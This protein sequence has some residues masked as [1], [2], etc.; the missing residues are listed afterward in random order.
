MTTFAMTGA[1]GK[2][3]QY[4]LKEGVVD[5]GCDI[6]K[7]TTV[8]GAFNRVR[9]DVVVHLASISD[10]NIC[11]DPANIE[12]VVN[13]NIRG[14]YN[15]L[16][17][18]RYYGTTVVLLSTE[19]VFSGKRGWLPPYS[20]KSKPN[21]INQYGISKLAAEALQEEFDNLKIVRTSYLFDAE[22]LSKVAKESVPSFMY[23]SFMYIPHFVS[24][25]MQYL[26]NIE[27]MPN[28]LHLSGN[29]TV[30]WDTFMSEYVGRGNYKSHKI[31]KKHFAPRP[32]KGGLRTIY[33]FFPR[34]DYIQ[35]LQ[36]MKYNA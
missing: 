28:L 11:Q 5:L 10:A 36:E 1:N 35:G 33:P 2:L 14:T 17:V 31:D 20:E 8:I 30:S 13:V 21:P 9:P 19:H 23:R 4:F 15:V 26:R 27:D 12:E 6:T 32:H 7:P 18:A 3:G 34:R 25:F 29:K 22:R 24:S 16:D